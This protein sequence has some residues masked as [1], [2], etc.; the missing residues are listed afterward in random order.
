MFIGCVYVL[1][2]TDCIGEIYIASASKVHTV[3]I[4]YSLATHTNTFWLKVQV[5]LMLVY[6]Y[7][8]TKLPNQSASLSLHHYNALF[9]YPVYTHTVPTAVFSKTTPHASKA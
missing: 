6:R 8:T 7:R 4:A 1:K 3:V 9:N 2:A 5:L